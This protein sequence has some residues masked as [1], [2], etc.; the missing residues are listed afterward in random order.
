MSEPQSRETQNRIDIKK[1]AQLPRIKPGELHVD[2][3]DVQNYLQHYGYVD[4]GS[5]CQRGRLCP[6]TTKALTRFQTFNRMSITGEFDSSTRDEMA[7]PRCGVPDFSE[8]EF[9]TIGAWDRKELTY[10]FGPMTEQAVGSSAAQAAVRRAIATWQSAGV[11]L[12]LSEVTFADNPDIRVEWRPAADPDHSMVG[13]TLAHADFPP[14]FSIITRPGLPLPVHFDDVEHTWSDGI[15][16]GAFDIE[17][18]ALHEFGHILGLLHTNVPGAVMFPSIGPAS[19]NR[20]L[21][22]DD[23]NALRALYG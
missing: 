6:Q 21:Q 3:E 9:R 10:A 17:T 4:A 5:G 2:L 23:L 16:S 15:E 14:G 11:G 13:G 7:K 1:I 8:L 19:E 22:T 12:Q 20:S 18:V